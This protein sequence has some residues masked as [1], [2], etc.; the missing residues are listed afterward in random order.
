MSLLWVLVLILLV[1]A[2]GGGGWGYGRW[3]ARGFFPLGLILLIIF[4][5]WATGHLHLPR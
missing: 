3:G 2:I 5:L 1:V 4:V